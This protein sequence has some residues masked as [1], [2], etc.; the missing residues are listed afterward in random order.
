MFRLH[1]FLFT[2]VSRL[3]CLVSS[4]LTFSSP[5]QKCISFHSSS[6]SP[7]HAWMFPLDGNS[8]GKYMHNPPPTWRLVWCGILRCPRLSTVIGDIKVL[9]GFGLSDSLIQT[10]TASFAEANSISCF[11]SSPRRAALLF[12]KVNIISVQEL[13]SRGGL[14]LESRLIYEVI[15]DNH[16]HYLLIYW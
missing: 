7:L 4:I 1:I 13:Q 9:R 6:A 16:I 15:N 14:L 10:H 5:D 11:G 8:E 2:R 3:S 12:G